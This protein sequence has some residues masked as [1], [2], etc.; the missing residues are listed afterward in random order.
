[1]ALSDPRAAERRARALDYPYRPAADAY[2]FTGAAARP[3][4]ETLDL[5]HRT[6]VIAAGSNRAPAQLQRKFGDADLLANVDSV[7]ASDIKRVA[8]AALAT[9]PSFVAFGD[10]AA[11]PSQAEVRAMF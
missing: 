2:L 6:P 7:S 1:M 11:S 5:R 8:A 4:P 10:V 3:W 9:N